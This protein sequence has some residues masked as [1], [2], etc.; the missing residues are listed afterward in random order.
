MI[1]YLDSS[2]LLRVILEQP[3]SLAEWPEL[4]V[5]V[6]SALLTVECHRTL[7]RYWQQDALN[8]DSYAAKRQETGTLLGRLDLIALDQHVLRVASQPFPTII[9]SLDAIH[10]ASAIAYR[11]VQPPDERPIVFATHD[12]QLARAARAMNFEVLGA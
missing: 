9:R 1:A 8:D 4:T 6:S 2:V 3:D 7:D 12:H 5:G 10:L 11:A